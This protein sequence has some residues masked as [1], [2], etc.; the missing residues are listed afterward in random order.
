MHVLS[1]FISNFSFDFEDFKRL[2]CPHVPF[3]NPCMLF[4]S[5]SFWLLFYHSYIQF[6]RSVHF[7]ETQPSKFLLFSSLVIILCVLSSMFFFVHFPFHCLCVLLKVCFQYFF[8]IFSCLVSIRLFVVPSNLFTW[9]WT[10]T[11]LWWGLYILG[12]NVGNVVWFA[13]FSF[14]I[15]WW[16]RKIATSWF[17]M[18]P[19]PQIICNMGFLIVDLGHWVKPRST[20]WYSIFLPLLQNVSSVH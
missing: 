9:M 6:K 19:Q 14:S 5:I 18:L 11:K 20:T 7:V 13:I 15:K 4:Q 16:S 10:T 17:T 12:Q 3:Y 2:L 8:Y 1:I